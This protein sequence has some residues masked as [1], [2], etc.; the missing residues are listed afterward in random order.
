MS[1]HLHDTGGTNAKEAGEAC[2]TPS[3][4]IAGGRS[5][6]RAQGHMRSK[7]CSLSVLPVRESVERNGAAHLGFL[8]P[9]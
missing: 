3:V 2:G 5:T 9:T 1:S 6:I 7:G 4:S 8:N